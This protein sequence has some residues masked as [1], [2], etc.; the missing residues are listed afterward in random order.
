MTNTTSDG[1]R[2]A[3]RR[4]SP[5]NDESGVRPVLEELLEIHHQ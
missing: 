3:A 1:V 5:T 4:S 2:K